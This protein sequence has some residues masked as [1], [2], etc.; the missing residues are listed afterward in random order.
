MKVIEGKRI[1]GQRLGRV[2]LKAGWE[3]RQIQG[4]GRG[5]EG[6]CRD[7]VMGGRVPS[8]EGAHPDCCGA[9]AQAPLSQST[10]PS[11]F[12]FPPVHPLGAM[13]DPTRVSSCYWKYPGTLPYIVLLFGLFGPLVA[14]GCP[15][16]GG[17][18]S[19]VP[20]PPYTFRSGPVPDACH[21]RWR[22]T[23]FRRTF[24]PAV[25]IQ[26]FSV[27]NRSDSG[28]G[29]VFWE[30]PAGGNP[31]AS[32]PARQMSGTTSTNDTSSTSGHASTD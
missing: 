32:R 29:R 25:K 30:A 24:W 20:P 18:E 28:A 3:R 17:S 1:E 16:S 13:A 22:Y 9:R 26:A 2:V 23:P 21:E 12:V 11:L 10:H 15:S 31:R 19:N 27:P 5:V 14:L 6:G 4:G 7:A 8:R